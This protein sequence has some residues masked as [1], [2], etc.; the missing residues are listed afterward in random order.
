M[1]SQPF[2]RRALRVELPHAE[3]AQVQVRAAGRRAW[4]VGRQRVATALAPQHLR[5]VVGAGLRALSLEPQR[6][7]TCAGLFDI[8]A[9]HPDLVVLSDPF[10]RTPA[11]AVIS[12]LRARGFV[13]AIVVL[14]HASR[15][16]RAQVGGLAGVTLVGDPVCGAT[17]AGPWLRRCLT[18]A[19]A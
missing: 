6:A 14:G 4:R 8:V 15:A 12:R 9:G 10:D 17:V 2:L 18:A 3:P 7:L 1:T 13:G 11:A 19:R 16:L 5:L